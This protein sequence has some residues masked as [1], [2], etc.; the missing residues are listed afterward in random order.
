MTTIPMQLP[1]GYTLRPDVAAVADYLRLR[2]IAGL[3]PRSVAAAE[4]GLPRTVFGVTI[5]HDGRAVAMGR[6]VG[7]GALC[8]QI[9]DIAVDPAH[10]SRGLGKAVMA[11]LM[12]HV[13][14]RTSAEVYVNLI[15]DGDAHRLYAQF[16]FEP[17]APLSQGMACWVHTR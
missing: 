10:Q 15:A 11:A 14:D 2:E 1:I 17:V 13:A 6:I 4:A 3:T 5:E 16:G 12:A 8:L 7:D 9:A